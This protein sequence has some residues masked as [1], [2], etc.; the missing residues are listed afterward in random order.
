MLSKRDPF[1]S[2][3]T[4]IENKII[5]KMQIVTKKT[6]VAILTYIKKFYQR[7]GRTFY[8]NKM[9]KSSKRYKKYK[10]IRIYSNV[11]KYMK[12]KLTELNREMYSSTIIVRYFSAPLSIINGTRQRRTIRKQRIW[13]NTINQLDLTNI[14][15]T[16]YPT[17]A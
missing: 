6:Q 3:N 4:E 15:R 14:Y 1:R 16:L 8:N 11:P 17:T 13:K 2:P 10:H 12:I 9:V 5:L 7:Q